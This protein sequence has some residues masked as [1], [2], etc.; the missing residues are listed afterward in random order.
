MAGMGDPKM[1]DCTQFSKLLCDLEPP[2]ALPSLD[3]CDRYQ[4]SSR[5]SWLTCQVCRN[6]CLVAIARDELCR[7]LSLTVLRV[8]R[9][10]QAVVLV[11]C[12]GD[13]LHYVNYL[14]I[15]L[16]MPVQL[17]MSPTHQNFDGVSLMEP[18]T[19]WTLLARGGLSHEDLDVVILRD[20]Q[21]YLE[22]DHPYRKIIQS[23]QNR[24]TR[25]LAIVDALQISS[26]G[27][28]ETDLCFLRTPLRLKC[29]L[30]CPE[31]PYAKD[32]TVNV[33]LLDADWLP[34]TGEQ[35]TTSDDA[36]IQQLKETVRTKGIVAARS[37]AEQMLDSQSIKQM[38][39]FLDHSQQELL[40]LRASALLDHREGSTLAL[41]ATLLAHHELSDYIQ[42]KATETLLQS[43][44]ETTLK[45]GVL[46]ATYSDFPT[47]QTYSWD[48]VVL[49]DLP[50]GFCCDSILRKAR[51][52]LV[53]CTE[54][55]WKTWQ[56]ALKLHDDLELLA[57]RV[58]QQSSNCARP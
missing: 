50:Y 17:V 56:T 6:N 14:R 40:Q 48:T 36:D 2:E 46:V 55:Q 16:P 3:E 27:G 41:T 47:L 43:P 45:S 39:E 10:R 13:H 1:G 51:Q 44:E 24:Q 37:E 30:G 21:H 19:M 18:H 26:L 35:Q 58:N 52:R 42:E 32:L 23:F 33:I 8:A 38:Q 31:R 34:L 4:P 49:Y 22:V 20:F 28:L 29:C 57:E 7:Q 5:E 25:L 54:P 12:I 53:L 11:Q 15:L 9:P